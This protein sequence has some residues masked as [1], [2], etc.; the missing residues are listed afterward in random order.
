ML[1]T[2]ENR[3]TMLN[4]SQH[5]TCMCWSEEGRGNG[6]WRM[7]KWF[8]LCY[9]WAAFIMCYSHTCDRLYQSLNQYL[10]DTHW[11]CHWKCPQPYFMTYEKPSQLPRRQKR[12]LSSHV[13]TLFP[14]KNR[15]DEMGNGGF[16]RCLWAACL[17]CH[18]GSLEKAV[19]THAE[20]KG[21][22]SNNA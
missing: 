21:K 16:P 14:C 18:C 8:S 20:Y 4:L 11:K 19:T 7:R 3:P 22:S 12:C 13:Y 17:I 2:K 5:G 10:S 9:V 1:S 6:G 15:N